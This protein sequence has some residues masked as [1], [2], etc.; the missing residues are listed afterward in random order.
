MLFAY[1]TADMARATFNKYK[2]PFVTSDTI[3]SLFR[4]P[5]DGSE[6]IMNW[7]LINY[8]FL[9]I[10][11]MGMVN[12][13]HIGHIHCL[14]TLPIP[15]PSLL[16]G[17]PRQQLPLETVDGKSLPGKNI[18]TSPRLLSI[19]DTYSLKKTHR[20]RCQ[21]LESLLGTMRYSYISNTQLTAINDRALSGKVISSVIIDAFHSF[22]DSLFVAGTKKGV[23][24]INDALIH[25]IFENDT[26]LGEITSDRD[27]AQ[28]IFEGMKIVV[29]K[30]INKIHNI[31]NGVIATIHSFD[32]DNILITLSNNSLHFLHPIVNE[33]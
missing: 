1:A 22:L 28:V 29:T 4:I 21:Y 13:V 19:M 23:D 8:D 18:F 3:H 2:S 30:N 31:V 26:P 11:E 7:N 33:D 9:V 14:K 20:F 15:L 25:H 6:P 32:K 16:A 10:D 5:I 24:I 27:R 17:D 12:N